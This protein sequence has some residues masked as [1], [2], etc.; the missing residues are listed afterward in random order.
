MVKRTLKKVKI[1]DLPALE[2]G[3]EEI[4]PLFRSGQVPKEQDYIKLI[5][6]VHY[7][8]KLLGIE[9]E[10]G[11]EPQ[12]GQGLVLS[13]EGVLS[14]DVSKIKFEAGDGLNMSD[15]GVLSAIGGT[16]ITSTADGLKMTSTLGLSALAFFYGAEFY[17]SDDAFN[18]FLMRAEPSGVMARGFSKG[19]HF[20]SMDNG[21]KSRYEGIAPEDEQQ[22]NPGQ[23]TFSYRT[24]EPMEVGNKIILYEQDIAGGG[25]SVEHTL[26]L[27]TF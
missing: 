3:F 26:V 20:L 19:A 17:A 12:L 13:D 9:G 27:T 18:V 24:S 15:D 10:E 23:F 5:E 8:H 16:G 1:D 7:L 11:H 21:S 22:L 4:K 25:G 14:V 6:Y 2:S